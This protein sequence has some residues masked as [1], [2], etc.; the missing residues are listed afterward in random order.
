MII[1]KRVFIVI[2]LFHLF[3]GCSIASENI[4]I[5]ESNGDINSKR[6]N[7]KCNDALDKNF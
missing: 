5:K 6:F 3:L 1:F 7:A 2:A 4:N